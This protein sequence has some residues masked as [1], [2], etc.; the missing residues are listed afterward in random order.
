MSLPAQTSL[1]TWIYAIHRALEHEGIDSRAILS[2]LEIDLDSLTQGTKVPKAWINA[3][4]SKAIEVSN[5]DAFSLRVLP[6]VI[7]PAL[8]ALLTSVQ[9]SA[10]IRQALAVLLRY[11][12]LIS[13]GT[14]I[15]LEI[16]ENVRLVVGDATPEPFLIPEDID[17]VFGLIRRFGCNLP[18]HK[19]KPMKLFLTRPCPQRDMDYEEFFECEV[20]FG[21]ERNIMVFS[22]DVMDA[23]IPSKNTALS[24]HI[25]LFLASKAERQ[26]DIE[27]KDRLH[28]ALIALLPGGVPELE[29]LAKRLHM[30][31][32]TLQR[33]LQTENLCF[34][35]ALNSVRLELAKK[36]LMDKSL[37]MHEIA[38]RLG[39]SEPSSF[40][41]FFKQHTQMS[42]SEFEVGQNK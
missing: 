26:D 38:Y 19:I 11:Y 10:D 18:R 25:E 1:A 16:D 37:P 41:R 30:S 23:D 4:W 42:P 22:L 40:A 14:K 5:N 39:F 20:C 27:I 34:K 29:Q 6:F 3:V 12:K 35:T 8:N 9:A 36:F 21:A 15:S 2:A 7:D 33:K 24:S 28:S 17:L 32:R 31:K 13:P